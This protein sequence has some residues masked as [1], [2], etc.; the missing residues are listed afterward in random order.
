[1]PTLAPY[2]TQYAPTG[3]VASIDQLASSAGVAMLRAGGNAVDAA[4][5]ANAVLAVTGQH[6]CGLGGDL[7]ALVHCPGDERPAC[8]N[9]SGRAGS[10]ADPE[11]LR[12]EGHAEI[13]R[14]GD[15]RATP[16]P[17][18]VDGWVALH[19]RFGRLPL[20]ELL[21]P[22]R[23]YAEHG[24]PASPTLAGW[25]A[26]EGLQGVPHADDY[27]ARGPLP[28]GA[29]IRRPGVARTLRAVADRGRQGFYQGEF[30][31]RLLELGNGEYTV[32]DLAR[33]QADWVEPI[34]VEAWD[35]RIWTVPPNSQGYITLSAAW[36]A[37]G[38]DLPAD[39]ADDLWAHLLVEAARQARFDR[40]DV[41]HEAASGEALIAAE[42]LEPRRRAIDSERASAPGGVR[43]GGDTMYLCAVDGERMGVSLIQS[44]YVG[45]GSMV[46]VP[47]VRIFLQN[48]GAGFS[49][50]P[51]HPAEYGPGRRPPHTLAPALVTNRD[52]S[53]SA[54]LGTMGGDGQPQIVLQLLARYYGVGETPG[55]TLAAA[56]FILVG[57]EG[58]AVEDHAPSGWLE[59]LEARGH[60][61]EVRPAWSHGFGHAHLIAV[62]DDRLAGA[63]DP[64]SLVGVAAGY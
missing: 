10:G 47:E 29:L 15:I 56:R 17:G 5:A 27:T 25:T 33:S 36:I 31:E 42:R 41:L 52:G 4:I 30:G 14:Q 38:L 61:V 21:E 55:E 64:R 54:V 22:A 43:A 3:M 39:P 8:L 32:D 13:P 23:A 2:A 48:R 40:D 63:A 51:G 24:F 28:P 62:E 18:C 34:S 57:A 58:V 12:A 26:S 45:F 11:R 46:V 53:L 60:A 19:E 50:E 35:R 7:F 16:V 20:G 44:N 49:L 1:M 59:G 6:L 37:Q 9:A